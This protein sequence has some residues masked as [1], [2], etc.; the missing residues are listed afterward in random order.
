[1]FKRGDIVVCIDND[2]KMW[3]TIG[4]SYIVLDVYDYANSNM[5]SISDNRGEYGGY[6]AKRFK[7]LRKCRGNKVKKLLK[8]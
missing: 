1:M 2:Q 8:D 6:Y 7:S 3:L 5:V 4:K